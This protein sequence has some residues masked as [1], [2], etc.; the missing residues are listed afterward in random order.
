VS[1]RSPEE[2]AALVAELRDGKKEGWSARQRAAADIERLAARVAEL[3]RKERV[4]LDLH[5]FLSVKFGEDIYAPIRHARSRIERL[6]K[7]AQATLLFHSGSPWTEEKQE[8]WLK[9][10]QRPEPGV[11][12]K[13]LCDFIR[14]ALD[15]AAPGGTDE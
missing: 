10:T 5:E 1:T 6:E 9:L 7:A 2:I 8:R 3:E 12:T 4:L 15:P 11:T 13:A 14:A